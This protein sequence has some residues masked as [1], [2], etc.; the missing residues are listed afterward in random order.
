MHIPKTGGTSVENWLRDQNSFH[1]H[2]FM[3]HPPMDLVCTPQHF[4]HATIQS[5]FSSFFTNFTYQ[6]AIV[7]NPYERL[8]SEFFYRQ[9][10]R[11]LRLGDQPEQYFSS[12]VCK[13]LN[14]AKKHP[15]IL[16]NHLRPQVEFL[17]EGVEIFY[18]EDGIANIISHV[19]KRIGTAEP[20]RKIHEK[21]SNRKTVYWSKKAINLVNEFYESDFEKLNYPYK[22]INKNI[23]LHLKDKALGGLFRIKINTRSLLRSLKPLLAKKLTSAG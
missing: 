9:K 4:T 20:L 13:M 22:K 8:E 23:T 3:K 2:L 5:L 18:F 19:A 11:Q 1:E 21:S 7:R 10:L 16:D 6:F 14:E 15:F 12:W 17:S